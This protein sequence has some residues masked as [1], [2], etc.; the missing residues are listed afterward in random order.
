[1]ESRPCV[2][3]L[4]K[5]Y[6]RHDRGHSQHSIHVPARHERRSE[7]PARKLTYPEQQRIGA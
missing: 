7:E 5:A 6:Y 3:A 1:M 2:T 4:P